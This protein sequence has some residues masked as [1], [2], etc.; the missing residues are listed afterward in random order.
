MVRVYAAQAL[1]PKMLKEL[2]IHS[3]DRFNLEEFA[4]VY[5]GLSVSGTGTNAP[6]MGFEG[7]FTMYKIGVVPSIGRNVETRYAFV[8][9]IPSFQYPIQERLVVFEE[10]CGATSIPGRVLRAQGGVHL[11]VPG[12]K[13][14]TPFT[15][16]GRVIRAPV[17][18]YE[19]RD[20]AQEGVVEIT[21][22][23]IVPYLQRLPESVRRLTQ[24]LSSR[25]CV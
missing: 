9:G 20:G 21:G 16:H 3:P 5:G 24:S 17:V 22:K 15:S 11:T 13:G 10:V 4:F 23:V 6:S 14:R 2:P 8:F 1:L 12:A 7:V 25:D 18:G 19:P